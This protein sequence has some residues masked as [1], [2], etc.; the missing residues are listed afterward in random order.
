MRTYFIVFII[1]III[2]TDNINFSRAQ[3]QP[4]LKQRQFS[5]SPYNPQV[6]DP[7]LKIE[8][9]VQGLEMP[10]TMAFVGPDDFFILEKDEG[11]VMRVVDG[12]ISEI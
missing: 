11:T 3:G 6:F 7:G 5:L 8:E 4:K 10:T 1:L 2:C 12:K 9:L